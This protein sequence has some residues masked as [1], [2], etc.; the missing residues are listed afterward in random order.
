VFASP[1][2]CRVC[3]S[4]IFVCCA[5]CMCVELWCDMF[6]ILHGSALC[7]RQLDNPIPGEL[8]DL[9]CAQSRTLSRQG[10]LALEIGNTKEKNRNVV[11]GDNIDSAMQLIFAGTVTLRK[12]PHLCFPIIKVVNKLQNCSVLVFVSGESYKDV[13]SE[14]PIPAWQCKVAQHGSMDLQFEKV[15]RSLPRH[16]ADD[17]AFGDHGDTNVFFLV[18]K[19]VPVPAAG[20][21]TADSPGI[22]ELT[23]SR[24]KVQKRKRGKDSNADFLQLIGG[25]GLCNQR[26]SLLAASTPVQQKTRTPKG[27]EWAHLL[28]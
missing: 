19:L 11:K 27:V 1:C 23:Y 10:G 12:T 18:P 26:L 20:A 24:K 8:F 22:V 4:F 14:C 2:N 7:T 21:R 6:Y 9:E 16:L 13:T 25:G 17:P 15:N 3:V 28:K 5:V